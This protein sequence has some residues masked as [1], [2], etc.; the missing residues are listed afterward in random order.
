[1]K[2]D[3][4]P[5]R[6]MFADVNHWHPLLDVNEYLD[7]SFKKFPYQKANCISIKISEGNFIAQHAMGTLQVAEQKGLIIIGYNYGLSFDTFMHAFPPKAGRIPCLDFEGNSLSVSGAELWVNEVSKEWGRMPLFYAGSAWRA[8]GQPTGTVVENCP[9]WG[10]QYSN[11][12]LVPNGVGKPVAWQFTD[13]K[14]GPGPK[15]FPGIGKCDIN[16]LLISYEELR[17]IA[18]MEVLH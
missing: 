16:S 10:P 18:G 17:L 6:Y 9:Y 3:F 2:I 5:N 7:K 8:L 4:D 15:S 13:G 12:L 11:H 1:M 14:F